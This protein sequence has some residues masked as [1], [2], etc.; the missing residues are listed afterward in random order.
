MKRF[1]VLIALF[2]ALCATWAWAQDSTAT[3]A[4]A[5]GGV[6]AF[7]SFLNDPQW[8]FLLAFVGGAIMR[9]MPGVENKAIPVVLQVLNVVTVLLGALFGVQFA[10]GAVTAWLPHLDPQTGPIMAAGLFGS[11]SLG[12]VLDAVASVALASGVQSQVK[13]VAQWWRMGR[14]ILKK[15]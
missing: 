4:T 13:N 9:W 7:M 3:A 1:G 12:A 5:A 11:L 14:V 10:P 15:Q 6:S 8:K 2:V